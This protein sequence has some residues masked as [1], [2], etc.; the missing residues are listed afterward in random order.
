MDSYISNFPPRIEKDLEAG[1]AT[2]GI[3]KTHSPRVGSLA[4]SVTSYSEKDLLHHYRWASVEMLAYY[5]R[6]QVCTCPFVGR[7]MFILR[8]NLSFTLK[9]YG[10][11]FTPP[12]AVLPP[13]LPTTTASIPIRNNKPRLGGLRGNVT[14]R[15][16][17]LLLDNELPTP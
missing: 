1:L 13:N 11:L 8:A 12:P 5:D 9:G 16:S 10:T 2:L 17:L 7:L 15:P 3:K 6:G 14:R 4:I